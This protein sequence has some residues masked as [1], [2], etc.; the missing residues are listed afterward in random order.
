MRRQMNVLHVRA[1]TSKMPSR[2]T[3]TLSLRMAMRQRAMPKPMRIRFWQLPAVVTCPDSIERQANSASRIAWHTLL[4]MPRKAR[5]KNPVSVVP[6][7][8]R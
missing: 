6:G 4:S 3:S 8:V 2:S 1:A 7:N 5:E